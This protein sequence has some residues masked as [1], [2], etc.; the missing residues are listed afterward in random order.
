MRHHVS[1]KFVRTAVGA[2]LVV[3]LLAGCSWFGKEDKLYKDDIASRP[4][5]VPPDLDRPATDAA[6]KMPPVAP[7]ASSVSGTPAGAGSTPLGFTVPGERDAIFAK[8]GDALGTVQG[9]NVASRAQLLGTYD[10]DYEGAKFLVRVT[11]TDA[12]VY[13]SAVDPRGLP[14]SGEAPVKLMTQLKAALGGG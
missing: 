7:T 2:A 3:G 8:V 6:M 1:L 14:A 9:V 13:V 4:L 11:K 10:V 5:E 12:G